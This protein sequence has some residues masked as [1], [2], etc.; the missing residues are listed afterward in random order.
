MA[1]V[2]GL[3]G[4]FSGLTGAG[5]PILSI[6]VMVALGFPPLVSI[7]AGQ[8]L[9]VVVAASGTLGNLWYGVVDFEVA[10]GITALQLLGLVV[11]IRL[12]HR[13]S[14]A[15]LRRLVAVVCLLVGAYGCLRALSAL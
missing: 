9:Q 1:G 3:V 8:V 4:F 11:G 12:S 6:P 14:P 15:R 7:A 10:A 2:G 13:V 5:G